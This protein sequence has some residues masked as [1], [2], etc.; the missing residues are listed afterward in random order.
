MDNRNVNLHAAIPPT[1]FAAL[2]QSNLKVQIEGFA[3]PLNSTLERYYSAFP[4]TDVV[5]GS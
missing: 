4:D 1:V 3:S 5:F 2:A